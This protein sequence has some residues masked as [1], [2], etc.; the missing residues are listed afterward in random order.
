M[1]GLE[2]SV[3]VEAMAKLEG[4][5][6]PIG[7]LEVTERSRGTLASLAG[8]KHA[9]WLLALAASAS[10]AAD[11]KPL[12]GTGRAKVYLD[13]K[14]I[15]GDRS[16]RTAW[17]RQDISPPLATSGGP[18]DAIAFHMQF[19]CGARTYRTQERVIYSGKG[20]K[21]RRT[22]SFPAASSDPFLAVPAGTL[23]DRYLRAACAK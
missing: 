17:F 16:A 6:I 10:H 4:I 15:A 19:N 8:L 22:G 3:W 21:R 18:V 1:S 14:S 9:V 11:W 2:T 23:I 12:A 20:A 5:G 7:H 13:A